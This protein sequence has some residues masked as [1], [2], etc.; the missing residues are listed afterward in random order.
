[1]QFESTFCQNTLC[2]QNMALLFLSPTRVSLPYLFI[3]YSL[4]LCTH[5]M[6]WMWSQKKPHQIINEKRKFE[7]A[8]KVGSMDNVKHKPA[9]GDKKVRCPTPLCFCTKSM[10]PLIHFNSAQFAQSSSIHSVDSSLET[11]LNHV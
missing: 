11:T 3:V 7:V 8:S 2:S 5:K 9:G 1:M 6:I 10:H 4:S